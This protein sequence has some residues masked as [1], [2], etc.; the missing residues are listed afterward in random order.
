MN[1]P[2]LL[3]FIAL[4][5][6]TNLAYAGD[7]KGKTTAQQR[8]NSPD[9]MPN[10]LVIK[11]KEN[12][13]FG[14]QT[15]KENKILK[16]A[17]VELTSHRQFL[18]EDAHRI[19]LSDQRKI[20]QSGLNRIY[21]ITYKAK[22]N[23]QE[24][25]QLLMAAGNLEYAEPL[26]MNKISVLPNDPEFLAGNQ[27]S[28]YQ[29][30]A[31]EAWAIQPNASNVVIAIIDS[32][33]DLDHPD[34]EA[35]IYVNTADPLNGVDDDGD[36]FVDN[37]K[38]WDFVGAT[39]AFTEDND[40]N[41]K[42][43]SLDHGV[44]VS[45]IASAVTNNGMGVA[46]LA[47]NARLMILKAGADNNGTSI[48]PSA[49]YKAMK[50]AA[51]RGVKII[52]CSWGRNTGPASSFEQDVVNYVV[53][54]G[55]LIVAAAGNDDSEFI[56]Y[57]AGYQGVFAVSNVQGSDQKSGSS[58]YGLH[59]ALSAP[60]TG[61]YNTT[62]GGSY[63]VKGGTS[64]AAPLVSSAAALVA[65]KYPDL[66]GIQIG[67]LLRIG[68]DDIYAIP[69]NINY[70]NKL[71][72]GRLNVYKALTVAD[73]PAIRKQN[74]TIVDHSGSRSAGDTL[75]LRIDVRNLMRLASNV[76][77]GLSSSS[78]AVEIL[79]PS[80]TIGSLQTFEDKTAGLFRV[81]FKSSLSDNEE[82]TFKLTYTS[83]PESYEYAE[84][85]TLLLNL[86]FINYKVNKI[87]TTATSNGRIGYSVQDGQS[88]AGFKYS[89]ISLL[90]E[91][92]LMIGT[93]SSQVADNARTSDGNAN[94]H[95]LKL[96]KIKK[97]IDS[98]AA[99]KAVSVFTD[100]GS[101]QPL[102]LEITHRQLALSSAPDDDYIIAEYELKNTNNYALANIHVGLFTDWDVDVSDKNIAKY[103]SDQR[104]S[105][106][107][108]SNSVAPYAGVK[109]LN[110]DSR[111]HFYPLSYMLGSDITADDEF[112]EADK[113]KTLSSGVFKAVLGKNEG[114]IDVMT[115]T[116]SGPYHLPAGES[117]KVAFAMMASDDL[118][119][120]Q[121]ASANA[122]AKYQIINN[123]KDEQEEVFE[124]SQNYPNPIEGGDFLT[125][126]DVHL[127]Q[128]GQLNIQL[129]DLTGKE[130]M[131]VTNTV[132]VQG[133]HKI[134]INTSQLNNGIYF[135]RALFN[136]QSKAVKIIVS[137]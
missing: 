66:S 57:P 83:A 120:L 88:G 70:L 69:Q 104:V 51:D 21:E 22:K 89:G 25:I 58:S 100:A 118:V 65:A 1:K 129:Y 95:F 35:N 53:S 42:A 135:C 137:R 122:Q 87:E 56:Q 13:L 114:G 52:N 77:V 84:Y 102:G 92:A 136:K 32:G 96:R 115:V 34:L 30:K 73:A 108:S 131:K 59:V 130:M 54:K 50:Y 49:A 68:S 43:D 81:L 112:S 75:N 38:G 11:Y 98:I 4:Y 3:I 60:G 74:V 116:S 5:I 126:V 127:P 111:S 134:S 85:F 36:G 17:A 29:V 9:Y 128:G 117:V 40:P 48:Y 125:T 132:Y 28:L 18:S 31:P 107:Y 62:F 16:A 79:D 24:V 76:L 123:Q 103:L 2:F 33:S 7:G 23:I 80:I 14:T 97:E 10:T 19:S 44:H 119:G 39:S 61:I 93:Q 41:V 45:G 99:F 12:P 27:H 8:F 46:S 121:N 64:M 67:E 63:G 105:Y 72:S 26:Y 90:Y 109:L 78:P 55:C 110:N 71:G 101:S 82:V 124:M 47:Q 6:A 106:V 94:N 91:G 86:D 37:Y 113:F 20:D 15:L 133:I